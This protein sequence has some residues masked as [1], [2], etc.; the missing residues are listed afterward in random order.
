MGS[1]SQSWG[2]KKASELGVWSELFGELGEVFGEG[3]WRV[4]R[5][6]GAQRSLEVLCMVHFWHQTGTK[7]GAGHRLEEGGL[8]PSAQEFQTCLLVVW[9]EESF[10][11]LYW[12]NFINAVGWVLRRKLQQLNTRPYQHALLMR[13]VTKR[14]DAED[15]DQ[16]ILNQ[17]MEYAG[18]MGMMALDELAHIHEKVEAVTRSHTR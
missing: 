13:G 14:Q 4:G 1:Q 8:Y 5:L 9:P 17:A 16:L 11:N 15:E 12:D 18:A 6:G 7:I 3:R 2:G 10:E